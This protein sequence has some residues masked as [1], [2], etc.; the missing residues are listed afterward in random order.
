MKIPDT[1]FK[2][3]DVQ[4]A[5]KKKTL[6]AQVSNFLETLGNNKPMAKG[7]RKRK[8]ENKLFWVG[9]IYFNLNELTRCTGPEPEMEFIQ[10]K[11]SWESRVSAIVNKIND[12][13]ESPV[14]LVNSRPWPILSVRDG[15]HRYEALVRSRKKKYWCLFWF[16][17]LDEQN[18]FVKKYNLSEDL[19]YSS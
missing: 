4:N 13:W 11:E 1:D 2:I 18:A 19:I 5:F 8:S 9:P 10:S 3:A 16:E 6:D 17:N 7:L 14:L 15:N 12:D